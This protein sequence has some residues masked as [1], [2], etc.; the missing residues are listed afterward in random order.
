MLNN[1]KL[2]VKICGMTK[3]ED[4]DLVA[5]LNFDFAGFIFAKKSPRYLS[6]AQA[7]NLQSPT[8]KRVGVFVDNSPTELLQIM[9]E[10]RLDFAQLHGDQGEE[11][12][13]SLQDTKIIKVFW[14][15]RY[16][17]A[18]ELE[19]EMQRFKKLATFFLIDAGTQGG[20]TGKSF[21]WNIM[22]TIQVPC[23]CFLAGG[24]SPQN[25]K[26]AAELNFDNFKGLDFN[27]GVE[28]SPG[29]K[30]SLALRQVFEILK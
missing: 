15:Q 16:S 25:A 23:P 30:D 10:A 8:L 27:S 17:S 3:Q 1:T 14:A 4:L 29:K 26:Q 19:N 2:L 22:K 24:L 9:Q 18:V 12:C 6:L 20:G 21:D 11:F 13:K 5:S 7:A 28:S